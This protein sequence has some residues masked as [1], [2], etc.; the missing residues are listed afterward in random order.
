MRNYIL[1]HYLFFTID[2]VIS[3]VST[4]LL[5]LRNGCKL[6]HIEIENVESVAR[7]S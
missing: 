1:L 4:K 5:S 6:D 3:G 7:L 2:T